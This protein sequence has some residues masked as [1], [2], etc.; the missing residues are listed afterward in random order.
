MSVIFLKDVAVHYESL[1]RGRPVV[2]LHTWVGS[3]RYWVPSMQV[4]AASHGTYA[5]DL[6][7]F[8]DSARIPG[9]Y[10]I[11]GQADLLRDFLDEMGI[12]RIALVGHGLGAAVGLQ[13]AELSPSRVVRIVG[14]A[15]PPDPLS[16]QD[17]LRSSSP[18][19]LAAVLGSREAGR[20]ALLD[21]AATI[22][23]GAMVILPDQAQLHSGLHALQA[24]AVPTI[25][26]YGGADPLVKPQPVDLAM[27]YGLNFHQVMLPAA[28]HYP[29]IDAA[30][31]FHRLLV[32][33]LALDPGASPR[34]IR[35]RE[36]W[37]RR[38]R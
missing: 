18:A 5:L 22:D 11:R 10:S 8:G 9:G 23:P 13:F 20:E 28:G 32:D 25:L 27:D 14:V 4:V 37:H 30:E 34:G 16:I 3:W 36:E 6:L 24:A 15:L 29:M 12:D 1:G 31:D 7:G 17:H 38:V 33:F 26:V 35:P 19:E 2:F 21:A